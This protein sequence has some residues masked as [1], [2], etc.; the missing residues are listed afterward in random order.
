[1]RKIIR[2]SKCYQSNFIWQSI[3]KWWRFFSPADSN[4]LDI[5]VP[6]EMWSERKW[7]FFGHFGW[8]S[9]ETFCSSFQCGSHLVFSAHIT[10]YVWLNLLLCA[11][12]FIIPFYLWFLFPFSLLHKFIC[13]KNCASKCI[14]TPALFCGSSLSNTRCVQLVLH[15]QILHNF[16]LRFGSG[17]KWVPLI[18]I[19]MRRWTRTNPASSSCLFEEQ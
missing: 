6:L 16:L 13:N 10:L 19:H 2:W 14:V 5:A 7:S 15:I 17:P 4:F 11:L 3:K 1:M 8:Q 9:S 12:S 18:K